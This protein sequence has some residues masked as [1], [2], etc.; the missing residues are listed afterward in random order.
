MEGSGEA[1]MW[2]GPRPVMLIQEEEKHWVV[3]VVQRNVMGVLSR[4]RKMN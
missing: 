3:K 1:L 4:R 2:G